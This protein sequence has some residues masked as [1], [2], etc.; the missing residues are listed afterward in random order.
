MSRKVFILALPI[1]F[2]FIFIGFA[3]SQDRGR[4]YGGFLERLKQELNLTP[5]QV[6]KIQK[7]LDSAQKQAEIDREKYQGNREAMMKAM[8]ER[9]EKIDKEIEAVLTKEQK[10]KYEAIKKERQER[11]REWRGR[12]S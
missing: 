1:L 8:R 3:L 7:I 12:P 6:T 10:K 11:M 2:S 9:W 5:E 4:G